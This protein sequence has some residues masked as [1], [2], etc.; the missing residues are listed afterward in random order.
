MVHTWKQVVRWG[1]LAFVLAPAAGAQTPAKNPDVQKLVDAYIQAWGKGDAKALAAL[2][3]QDAVRIGADGMVFSGRTAIEQAFV[4]GF[5]TTLKGS[6][7]SVTRGTETSLTP[8]IMIGSGT[9]S[10]SGGAPTPGTPTKGSFLNTL[11]RQ[12][13]R[14]LI[15]SNAAVGAAQ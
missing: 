4:K 8:D 13:G 15:A 14:W 2:F 12:G 9:W 7:L 1:I 6:T 5:E 3:T 10:V 11:V